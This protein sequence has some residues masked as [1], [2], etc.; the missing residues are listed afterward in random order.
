MWFVAGER[1]RL[2]CGGS[3]RGALSCSTPPQFAISPTG[4]SLCYTDCAA[5]RGCMEWGGRAASAGSRRVGRGAL[6][7]PHILEGGRQKAEG[8]RRKGTHS[9]LTTHL[10]NHA[11]GEAAHAGVDLVG[12]EAGPAGLDVE[13][14]EG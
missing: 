13:D 10:R 2:T 14:V 11:L 8:R 9:P 6:S 4:S 3:R 12:G 5:K 7:P 1:L